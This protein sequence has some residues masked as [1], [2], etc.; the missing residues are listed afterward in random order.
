MLNGKFG[1]LVIAIL[2][3]GVIAVGIAAQ[4]STENR[5]HASQFNDLNSAKDVVNTINVDGTMGPDSWL[6]NY[7]NTLPQ[8][9]LG[10][11]QFQVTDPQQGPRPTEASRVTTTPPTHTLPTQATGTFG[12]PQALTSLVITVTKVEVHLARLA[13]PGQ[14]VTPPVEKNQIHGK[15]TETPTPQTVDKWEVLNIDGPQLVDLVQL[16]KTKNFSSLGFTK[17]AGG[18]YTEVRLYISNGKATLVDGSTKTLLI[19]GRANIVRV[20]EPFTIVSG[21]T[22]TLSLDFDANNSV[23]KAGDNYLLKPVV[24]RF[25]SKNQ[26]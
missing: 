20:V 13:T 3:I 6:G 4:Q 14:R 17:L 12:G 1:L 8:A 5:Q 25:T 18:L 15:P 21:K 2:A 23:I 9:A 22:T 7:S 11:L 24:A 16:A 19:P 10:F 26:E